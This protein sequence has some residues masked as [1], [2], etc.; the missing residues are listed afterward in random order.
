MERNKAVM[1]GFLNEIMNNE[2]PISNKRKIIN[3]ITI[4]NYP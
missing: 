1:V 2:N 4:F 3:T